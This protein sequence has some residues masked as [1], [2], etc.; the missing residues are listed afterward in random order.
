MLFVF[1]LF[2]DKET[3]DKMNI[4]DIMSFLVYMKEFNDN[5][6]PIAIKYG[7]LPSIVG[8]DIGAILVPGLKIILYEHVEDSKRCLLWNTNDLNVMI[9]LIIKNTKGRIKNNDQIC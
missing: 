4:K 6:K 5:I 9:V 1:K 2:S 8:G 3:I 7:I